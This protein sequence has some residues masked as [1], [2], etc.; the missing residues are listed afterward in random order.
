[1]RKKKKLPKVSANELQ[2]MREWI[3]DCD[4]RESSGHLESLTSEQVKRGIER[5]YS[6]GVA[7]FLR[8]HV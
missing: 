7:E 1:M 2:A 5:H 4:W 3:A 6:G 8:C